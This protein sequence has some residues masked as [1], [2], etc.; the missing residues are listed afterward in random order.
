MENIIYNTG[1]IR[2]KT[3]KM[4]KKLFNAA[5]AERLFNYV[6]PV[7]KE[8]ECFVRNKRIA[9]FKDGEISEVDRLEILN[10]S[11]R[12]DF[13]RSSREG[14]SSD[15][16]SLGEIQTRLKFCDYWYAKRLDGHQAF[17]SLV[18]RKTITPL[19]E[20]EYNNISSLEKADERL[21]W[22]FDNWG[23]NSEIKLCSAKLKR[24]H[25]D[26]SF[27]TLHN[28]PIRFFEII[29]RQKNIMNVVFQFN[30]NESNYSGKWENG[31][32]EHNGYLDDD[33]PF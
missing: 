17:L 20:D 29:L 15:S 21:R 18:D 5:T 28:P 3:P 2:C 9:F 4:A 19:R 30:S 33:I 26:L 10:S 23:V 22:C 12:K 16:L 6:M 8:L 32:M 1:T 7:P 25:L 31:V 27:T 24:N 13:D 11:I 14:S